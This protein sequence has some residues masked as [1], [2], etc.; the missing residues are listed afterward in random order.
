LIRLEEGGLANEDLGPHFIG[1]R[2]ADHVEIAFTLNDRT[3][4]STERDACAEWQTR[5][6]ENLEWLSS[7]RVAA[8]TLGVYQGAIEDGRQ[9][10]VRHLPER[11]I[12]TTHPA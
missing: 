12:V 6:V 5:A 8:E 7:P 3:L 4:I 10:L 11:E 1:T 2:R 9:G